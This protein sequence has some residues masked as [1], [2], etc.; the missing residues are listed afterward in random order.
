[1]LKSA[2][3]A[4]GDMSA[5][6]RR[7]ALLACLAALGHASAAMAYTAGP[8]V[9]S[10][11]PEHPSS[12][13][14]IAVNIDGYVNDCQAIILDSVAGIRNGADVLITGRVSCGIISAPGEYSF[15]Y[16]LGLLPPGSYQ[17][18]FELQARA[19]G[20]PDYSSLGVLGTVTLA[21]QE[22]AASVPTLS[23]ASLVGLFLLLCLFAKYGRASRGMFRAVALIA[24]GA[25][26]LQIADSS[27]A[28]QLTPSVDRQLVLLLDPSQPSVTT[29]EIADPMQRE[30]LPMEFKQLLGVPESA[31]WL[32][33]DRGTDDFVQQLEKD[34]ASPRALLHRTLILT[35][36][37]ATDAGAAQREL[38][39]DRR[40]LS[41]ERNRTFTLSATPGD[42]Y[43]SVD[44]LYPSPWNYQW[45]MQMLAFPGAWDRVRGNSYVGYL[46]IGIYCVNAT[47]ECVSHADLRQNFR[48]QLSKSFYSGPISDDEIRETMSPFLGVLYSGHGTHVAGIIAA[49]PTFGAFNNG[50]THSG[51]AGGCWTCSLVVLRFDGS[52]AAVAEGL[53]FAADRGLQAVNM[54]FGDDPNQ[55]FTNCAQVTF[56]ATCNALAYAHQ[57]DV[58][59]VAAAGNH[60]RAHVQF[61][62]RAPEVIAVAGIN[63]GGQFWN[64]GYGSP[65]T[66][67]GSQCGSNYGPEVVVAA[68][69]LDVVS[70]VHPGYEW[71]PS[72]HCGDT[73]GPD[74][75]TQDGYGDC[76]GTSMAAPHVSAVIAL[77][78]SANPLLNKSSIKATL[79]ATTNPCNAPNAARCGSGIPN[80]TKAV[81]AV[82]GGADVKNLLTP[83]FSFYSAQGSNHFYTI[84]PQMGASALV[85]GQLYPQPTIQ[86]FAYL[87]LGPPV[88]GYAAFPCGN[89][90][91]CYT[92]V[93]K[94]MFSV[95]TTHTNPIGGYGEL[96]PLY[97]LSKA[98]GCCHSTHVY[99]T[100]GSEVSSLKA[101]SYKLDGIEGYIYP[102]TQPRPQ[103]TVKLC[104]K[105]SGLTRDDYILFPSTGSLVCGSGDGYTRD[106]GNVLYS[107]YTGTYGGTDWI[108]W[109]HPVAASESV[110][111]G[112]IPCKVAR[113]LFA[114]LSD[115]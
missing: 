31:R 28:Q 55:D 18:R 9:F 63:A 13:T 68:P 56:Q 79:A 58:A 20:A 93:P 4:F 72:N 40:V 97:R 54:S 110:C 98:V 39:K 105:Y 106:A 74:Y 25:S 107:D 27:T 82:L 6:A 83:M 32:I 42:K 109:V 111:S 113:S 84:F 24:F 103:G 115:D 71:S 14:P 57:R 50:Q 43:F 15:N 66:P 60:F 78:R 8:V 85:T 90:L 112:G 19:I 64:V 61:P 21:V 77:M 22:S 16:A 69:A 30:R 86:K 3:V 52:W 67:E 29:D 104:R 70:T 59:I 114:L 89:V 41:V 34:P 10:T 51:V 100:S 95:F 23:P 53:T 38:E 1:M 36:A 88:S 99:T 91:A 35:Y 2:I 76:T 102:T 96:A 46:D 33:S 44:P 17:V 62:A 101:A 73:Y 65:C 26:L 81:N 7:L 45:G 92:A 47:G 75:G 37:S 12:S 48:V 80:A 49:T 5:G 11:S 108:G 94:G 87:S